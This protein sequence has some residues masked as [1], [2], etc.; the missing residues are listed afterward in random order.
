MKVIDVLQ[1]PWAILPDRL[2]ELTNIYSTHLRGEKIDIDGIEARIGEP[3]ARQEQGYDVV[4]GVAIIPIDG[5]IAKKMNLFT[6]ISGGASTQLIERDFLQAMDD[7]EVHSIIL[8]IDTPGGSVDG[9]SELATKIFEARGEKPIYTLADGLMASAGVW[10]GSAADKVFVTADTTQV[11]SIGVVTSHIDYSEAYRKRGITITEIYAGKYK[12]IA[13]DVKPLD[14]A[15]AAYLQ[16]RVDYL[17]SIFV[18]TIAKHRD[19]PSED[20]LDRMA[21]GKLFI[22]QQAIDVGLADGFATLD[23]LIL[24]LND[25]EKKNSDIFSPLL[26]GAASDDQDDIDTKTVDVEIEADSSGSDVSADQAEDSNMNLEQLKEKHPEAVAEAR[27]VGY[28]AGVAESHDAAVAE[29]TALEM[30]RIKDVKAQSMPGH[31]AL[32]E[33]LMFDGKTTGE[34]A[35]VA[36]LNAEREKQESARLAR[37]EDAADLDKLDASVELDTGEEGAGNKTPEQ[38]LRSKWDGDPKLRA[39]FADQFDR[40]VAFTKNQDRTK[41]LG[42]NK[43]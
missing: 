11:G 32:I 6:R 14:K 24:S 31:E 33:T 1:S 15:G 27:Q 26:A 18:D 36:V 8:H 21:D 5:I 30:T 41:I 25:S 40:F 2:V 19:T 23:Q 22:G 20:V 9:T 4:D 13:S 38:R 43:S 16:G 39:E 3:L 42:G 35:A 17:Y 7:P 34:Q 29:G 10:I 12:R 37:Q 28:D